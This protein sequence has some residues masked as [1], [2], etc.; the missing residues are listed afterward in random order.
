MVC[1][2][3]PLF[4]KSTEVHIIYIQTLAQNWTAVIKFSCLT[5]LGN[6]PQFMKM[7][8]IEIFITNTWFCVAMVYLLSCSFVG[9]FTADCVDL[10]N[11]KRKVLCTRGVSN[12]V[13]NNSVLTA[14]P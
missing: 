4:G 10:A 13:M 6:Y 2:M 11:S 8:S 5:T 14:Q 1:H 12:Q 3:L 7:K 9:S